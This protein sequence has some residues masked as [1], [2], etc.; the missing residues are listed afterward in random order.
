MLAREAGSGVPLASQLRGLLAP[1]GCGPT[2]RHAL[3]LPVPQISRLFHGGVSVTGGKPHLLCPEGGPCL[4]W[5]QPRPAPWPPKALCPRGIAGTGDREGFP[6][7]DLIVILRERG[8]ADI[9]YREPATMMRNIK[10][11]LWPETVLFCSEEAPSSMTGSRM[12]WDREAT[13]DCSPN[14]YRT[15]YHHRKIDNLAR[16]H[17]HFTTPAPVPAVWSWAPGPGVT[18]PQ[19]TR[20]VPCDNYPVPLSHACNSHSPCNPVLP[21][22]TSSWLI[23]GSGGGRCRADVC[24]DLLLS[25]QLAGL[26]QTFNPDCCIG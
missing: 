10:P 1:L 26:E 7:Q 21:P 12:P 15:A 17:L 14:S 25:V 24:G 8:G 6:N 4:P 9:E 16:R 3:R 22:K 13:S 2:A 20:L 5:C 19:P 23:G 18:P 11:A